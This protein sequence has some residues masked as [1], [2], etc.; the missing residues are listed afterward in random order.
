MQCCQDWRHLLAPIEQYIE[1]SGDKSPIYYL[2]EKFKNQ[3]SSS[4]STVLTDL[5]DLL[6][7][8]KTLI[9]QAGLEDVLIVNDSIS[10]QK[11]PDL[12]IECATDGSWLR[13][14]SRELRKIRGQQQDFV[15]T[16]IDAYHKGNYRPKLEWALRK[17]RYAEGVYDLRHISKRKEFLE[18]FG[19]ADGECWIVTDH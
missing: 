5:S 17:A 1:A 14:G 4:Q 10:T 16:M 12:K 6:G 7:Q 9:H 3:R 19:Q 2:N 15:L 18:F 11:Y 13:V 8:V